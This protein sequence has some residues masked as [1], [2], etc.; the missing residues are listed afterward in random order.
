M[1]RKKYRHPVVEAQISQY[2]QT[3]NRYLVI[4]ISKPSSRGSNEVVSVSIGLSIDQKLLQTM[5][6]VNDSSIPVRTV[7]TTCERCGIMDCL[8]RAAEPVEFIKQQ[9]Q[10]RIQAALMQLDEKN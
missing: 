6:F 9:Q 8:E 3:H 10:E 7:H 4:S 1:A 2:W 5:P